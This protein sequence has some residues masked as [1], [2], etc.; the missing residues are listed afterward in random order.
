MIAIELKTTKLKPEYPGK[1]QFYPTAL[2][3]TVKT[4]DE[5]PAI[6][7]II[8]KDKDRTTVEYALKDMNSPLGVA[9]YTLKEELPSEMRDLLPTPEEIAEQLEKFIE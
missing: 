5:N 4:E 7:I 2:N 1:L 9:T 3:E 8:C 6:G